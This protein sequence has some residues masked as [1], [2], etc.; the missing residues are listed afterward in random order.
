MLTG[1]PVRAS[2]VAVAVGLAVAVEVGLAVAVA[3]GL[4]VA[5]TVAVGLAVAVAVAVGL[6]V[7]VAVAIPPCSTAKAAGAS[8]NTAAKHNEISNN[9]LLTNPPFP[10]GR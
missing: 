3:V 2:V 4:A 5:V 10:K 8:T 9:N 6:A 1:P 7:A